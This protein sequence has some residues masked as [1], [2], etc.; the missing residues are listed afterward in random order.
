MESQRQNLQRETHF[1]LSQSLK[2]PYDNSKSGCTVSNT[3]VIG[4]VSANKEDSII[5]PNIYSLPCSQQD[6]KALSMFITDPQG[7]LYRD[8]AGF[9]AANGYRIKVLNLANT[10]YSDCYNPFMYITSADSLVMLAESLVENLDNDQVVR[11]SSQIQQ[12]AKALL[13][14]IC[15]YVYYELPTTE[16]NFG[17]V[18]R[19]L[20]TCSSNKGQIN[21]QSE[22][23]KIIEKLRSRS[24]GNIPKHPAVEWYDKVTT[25]SEEWRSILEAAQAAVNVFAYE[26]ISRLTEVD[27]LDLKI[28]GN[29]PTAVFVIIPPQTAIYTPLS[30]MICAQVFDVLRA[31][32]VNVYHGNL[33]HRVICWL[34]GFANIGKIPRLSHTLN[35]ISSINVSVE[36]VSHSP[37]K[38]NEWYE[39]QEL[40]NAFQQIIYMGSSRI[41]ENTPAAWISGIIQHS[42]IMTQPIFLTQEEISHLALDKC[43][44]IRPG[45]MLI[46]DTKIDLNSCPNFRS[47]AISKQEQHGRAMRKEFVW[48]FNGQDAKRKTIDSYHEGM[49]MM[50]RDSETR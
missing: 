20:N 36:I 18:T 24:D 31:Q 6:G 9:L 21:R 23:H 5:K 11:H 27:T 22:Y 39:E 29:I 34:N 48:E 40:L 35:E 42:C 10:H 14:S 28:I 30:A 37:Y 41:G 32:A 16:R 2:I 44:I 49:Q 47:N 19:M 26:N 46:E 25:C 12:A 38:L 45:Q 15:C 13:S 43:L 3:L 8:C 1:L 4:E 7:K 33:P 17:T 50:L